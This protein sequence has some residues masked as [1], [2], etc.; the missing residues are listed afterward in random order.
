MSLAPPP[1]YQGLVVLDKAKHKAQGIRPHAARFAAQLHTLYLTVAE[2]I[3]A[4]RHYPITF[5]RD[6]QG[7]LHPFAV[8]GP[9][10]GLNLWVDAQ[11]DWRTDAYCPA[12]VRRYPF[13]TVRALDAGVTKSVICVDEAGLDDTLPHLF[14]SRSEPTA[15]WRDLQRL[16]EEFDSAQIQTIAFCA[17]LETLGLMEN[18]EADINPAFGRRTRLTGMFRV[19]EDALQALAPAQLTALV[20][21]GSLP[22]IYAHLMSLDNFHG[23]LEKAGVSNRG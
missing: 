20:R 23:L 15:Y 11:G 12:Y 17:R 22:R 16:I 8:V 3:A 18:F 14:D 10:P 5:A 21:D 7:A 4:A 6:A 13:T 1:G 9:A 19:R 2:F